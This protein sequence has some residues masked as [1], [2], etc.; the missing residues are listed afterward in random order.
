VIA[1][2][3]ERC[4]GIDVA[5]NVLNVCVMTG[6]VADEPVLAFRKFAAFNS[7]LAQ[8]RDWLVEV[9]C[10]Q[11][12]MESTGSY[13][14]PVFEVLEDSGVRVILAN[15]EDVKARRGHKTDWKTVSFWRIFYA[16]SA[17]RSPSR[18]AHPRIETYDIRKRLL[19]RRLFNG[20]FQPKAIVN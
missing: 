12:V 11:V 13:W 19:A 7:E 8:L 3:V 16:A 17:L 15:G 1:A 10:T 20:T 4:A 5:K 9:G 18:D 6:A 2:V 14:K